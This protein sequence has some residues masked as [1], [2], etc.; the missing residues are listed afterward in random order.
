LFEQAPW[1]PA[2][3]HCV[4]PGSR[5]ACRTCGSPPSGAAQVQRA[6]GNS[7]RSPGPRAA[8][9]AAYVSGLAGNGLSMWALVCRGYRILRPQPEDHTAWSRLSSP[10]SDYIAQHH[11][12]CQGENRAL[13][14][15]GIGWIV[16]TGAVARSVRAAQ[17]V[18]R[19]AAVIQ[20]ALNGDFHLVLAPLMEKGPHPQARRVASILID[21][22]PA[23]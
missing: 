12:T 15:V 9:C 23:K 22:Q 8:D 11:G 21:S 14:V 6:L 20:H 4:G 16:G 3:A 2:N 1:Q 17:R 5:T 10:D 13:S 18:G 19:L 7:E